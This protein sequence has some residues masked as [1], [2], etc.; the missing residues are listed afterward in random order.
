M[1]IATVLPEVAAAIEKVA[2]VPEIF[3]VR[4]CS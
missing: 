3:A 2:V 4:R 1:C